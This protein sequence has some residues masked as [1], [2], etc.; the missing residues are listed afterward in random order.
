MSLM[1]SLTPKPSNRL[2]R[3]GL[4]LRLYFTRISFIS[5][6]LAAVSFTSS[7]VS[8]GTRASGASA[9]ANAGSENAQQSESE[10]EAPLLIWNGQRLEQRV[11]S[12][13]G[14]DYQF[15][16]P[17]DDARLSRGF[18]LAA[19]HSH[20][21]IDLAN[22]RGTPILAAE[23][24]RVIYTGN[25]FHGYGNLIVIE[26]GDEWATLYSHL[27]KIEVTEGQMIVRG[28][29][30]GQMGRTGRA[31]GNHLH[32]EIRHFRQPVNPL[33]YLPQGLPAR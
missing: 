19:R 3:L 11:E 24:G 16:W 22:V 23:R 26:H 12:A 13:T 18:S 29:K 32:F 27:S 1:L 14:A 33:A 6:A 4:S 7:C 20:W 9:V 21:G 30:I 8:H 17:V 15:D 25:G 10:K 5:F 2:L 28:E 31:S